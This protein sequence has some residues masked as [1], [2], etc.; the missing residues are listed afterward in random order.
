VGRAYAILRYA[1]ILESKEALTHLSMLRLGSDLG[2][3]PNEY[4]KMLDSIL[5]DIQPAH[6]QIASKQRLNAP[7]RDIL[8]AQML[9]EKLQALQEPK[10]M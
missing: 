2:L 4:G 1:H 5:V 9:R 6:L 7:E 8:R 10:F 3:V